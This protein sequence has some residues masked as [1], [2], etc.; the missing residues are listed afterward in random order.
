M[1][2]LLQRLLADSERLL[3][4]KDAA[5]VLGLSNHKTL[6]NWRSQ[7]KHLDLPFVRIGRSIRYRLGALQ[8]FRL[9]HTVNGH[10]PGGP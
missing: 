3:T 6:A 7:R 5:E 10:H 8:D 4:E 2:A 9:R 1:S